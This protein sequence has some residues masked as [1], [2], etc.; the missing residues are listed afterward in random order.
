MVLELIKLKN[1]GKVYQNGDFCVKALEKICLCVKK[2]EFLAIL[3]ASGS[4]K[5]TLM[6]IIGCLDYPTSGEYFL[7]N[8]NISKA[9]EKTLAKI[10]RDKI[11]F[12]FQKFNLI[13]TLTA[14]ENV[15]LPLLYSGIDKKSRD[16]KSAKALELVSLGNRHNH[17]P[18]E[19]SGGQQQRIAIARAI[20]TSPEIILADEPTGN[21]DSKSA[22]K[23]MQLLSSLNSQGKTIVLI[24]HD[25]KT[26][27]YSSRQIKIIDGKI[28]N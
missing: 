25:E 26:A 4:G 8:I 19:L 1:V 15:A 20:V 22:G 12:V 6:N 3:G 14:F 16:E 21:L 5:S 24:T 7:D 23:I 28:I 27:D 9:N 11:G 18:C 10:R 2:G 13:P 17:K